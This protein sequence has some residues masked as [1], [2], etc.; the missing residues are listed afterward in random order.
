MYDSWSGIVLGN[1]PIKIQEP[2]SAGNPYPCSKGNIYKPKEVL[3]TSW[4]TAQVMGY[5]VVR[6]IAAAWQVRALLFSFFFSMYSSSIWCSSADLRTKQQITNRTGTK[7][8]GEVQL[9]NPIIVI[10]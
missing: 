5:L 3:S 8:L 7:K 6:A 1:P 9:V 10:S 2:A 4:W